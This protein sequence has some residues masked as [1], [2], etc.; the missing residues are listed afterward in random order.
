MSRFRRVFVLMLGL[1]A[2]SLLVVSVFAEGE[3]QPENGHFFISAAGWGLYHAEWVGYD[4]Y[5]FSG[6]LHVIASGNPTVAATSSRFIGAQDSVLQF[7]V[8]GLGVG[9]GNMEVRSNVYGSGVHDLVSSYVVNHG[10]WSCHE[11]FFGGFYGERRTLLFY[12]LDGY[13][14][15]LDDVVVTNAVWSGDQGGNT[16]TPMGGTPGG[17]AWT[18]TPYASS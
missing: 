9:D 15:L 1:F 4:G 6:A 12:V 8:K 11:T 14:Y 16:P 18:A 2:F 17:G 5:Q 13:E 7:C 3:T 10:V